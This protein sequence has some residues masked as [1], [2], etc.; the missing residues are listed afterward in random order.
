MVMLTAVEQKNI[1]QL[2]A[3]IFNAA[4]GAAYLQDL[5]EAYV[6]LGRDWSA[7][8]QALGQTSAFAQYYPETLSVSEYIDQFLGALG[9][10]DVQDA[11]DWLAQHAQAGQAPALLMTEALIALEASTDPLYAA[12]T[13]TL[14][15]PPAP[16]V[17]ETPAP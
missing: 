17:T 7:L 4:P 3:G 10:A 13:P 16:V 9:L 11:R 8:A 2:V 12:Y 15:T 1:H 14:L 6:A 5:A